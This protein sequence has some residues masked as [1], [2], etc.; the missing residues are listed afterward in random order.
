MEFEFVL[1]QLLEGFNRLKIRYAV[2]GGF[3]L[4]VHGY[5]RAT[6]D[7]DFLVH[8][9]DLDNLHNIMTSLNYSR[10]HHNENVS[11]YQGENIVWGNVDFLHAFRPL[12]LRMLADAVE[13]PAF[14][15]QAKLQVLRP[16]DIAGLKIQALANRP[17]REYKEIADIEALLRAQKGAVDWNRLEEYYNLFGLQEKFKALR[18][19]LEHAE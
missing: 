16:E 3:S 4:G 15:G 12:A 8:R 1:K 2:M 11:Q 10:F 19:R 18:E 9:G 7:L 14:S 5:L 17:D 6:R 13:R